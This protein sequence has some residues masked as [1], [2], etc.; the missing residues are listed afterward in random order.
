MMKNYGAVY[1]NVAEVSQSDTAK[2]RIAVGG[3]SPYRDE[4][5]ERHTLTFNREPDGAGESP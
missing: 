5:G 4:V 3:P 1:Q 2:T